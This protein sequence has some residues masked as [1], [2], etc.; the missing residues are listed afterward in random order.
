MIPRYSG[1]PWNGKIGTNTTAPILV[2][3]SPRRRRAVLQTMSR[4]PNVEKAAEEVW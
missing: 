2:A 4:L 3:A 1:T